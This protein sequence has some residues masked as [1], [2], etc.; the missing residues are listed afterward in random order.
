MFGATHKLV[1]NIVY[2][3]IKNELG[4][5]LD[6]KSFKNGSIAPDI[7]LSMRTIKHTRKGSF[8]LVK[9]IG[10]GLIELDN[11][12]LAINMKRFSYNLGIIIHFLCDYFCTPHNYDE[13]KN[14]IK[15]LRYE[16]KLRKF[17]HRNDDWN[18][19]KLIEAIDSSDWKSSTFEQIVMDKTLEYRETDRSLINDM[20]FAVTVSTIA[21]LI[22]VRTSLAN[23]RHK[24]FGIPS[25]NFSPA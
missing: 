11:P 15:H 4:V 14:I 6:L 3:H 19:P 9:E 24:N 23:A 12:Y 22:I 1:A 20:E 8:E 5:C 7:R 2:E 21:T 16:N 18:F 25:V 13:Y 17:A 10:N